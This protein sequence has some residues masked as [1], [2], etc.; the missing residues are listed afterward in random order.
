M[1]ASAWPGP[2]LPPYVRDEG[3]P[4]T[5]WLWFSDSTVRRDLLVVGS[6]SGLGILTRQFAAVR[7]F[8][9]VGG[10]AEPLIPYPGA[11]FDC[12]VARG[13]LGEAG[14]PPRASLD[15]LW[16]ECH[17]VL[18][19]GGTLYVDGPNPAWFRSLPGNPRGWLARAQR[20]KRFATALRATGFAEVRM[21]YVDPELAIPRAIIPATR[22][23]VAAW[24]RFV[25]PHGARGRGRVLL[26][27]A[28][29]HDLLYPELFLLAR[30]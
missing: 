13:A 19:P 9:P 1:T 12:V 6:A 29:R 17:W 25:L 20:L 5:T 15:G 28:G 8:R 24:E 14:D 4:W 27:L 11:S 2:T 3:Q 18:R 22:R 7:E 30:R 21:Y 23:A 16:R 10:G 26:A